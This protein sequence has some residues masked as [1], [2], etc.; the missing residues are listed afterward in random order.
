MVSE[1]GSAIGDVLKKTMKKL[2][3]PSKPSEEAVR[4]LWGDA[5]GAAAA[6]HSNPVA[7]KR[8]ELVVDVD[9]S[10]WL[11]ELTLKK[12]TILKA[13]DGKF[14]KKKIKNLRFRI[15]ELKRSDK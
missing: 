15:G 1:K 12:K 10:S 5:V 8:S 2:V 13:L 3:S 4:F 7:I 14:G 6:K 9:G 11:Y